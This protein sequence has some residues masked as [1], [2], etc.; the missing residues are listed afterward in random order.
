[1]LLSQTDHSVD[2]ALRRPGRF[3]RELEIGVP[4]KN[5]RNEILQIQTRHMPLAKDFDLNQITNLTHG[6]VGADLAA[7]SKEAGMQAIRSFT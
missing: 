7:L 1:L 5:G 4:D 3:D 2:P 6:F